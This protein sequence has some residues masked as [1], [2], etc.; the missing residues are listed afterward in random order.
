MFK[1][2]YDPLTGKKT[3]TG[4][5]RGLRVIN[6]YLARSPKLSLKSIIE[7]NK[8]KI[9]AM[10]I[11]KNLFNEKIGEN[12][13]RIRNMFN[14]LLK[15]IDL[16]DKCVECIFHIKNGKYNKNRMKICD[17]GRS[18]DWNPEI[19]SCNNKFFD[20][21]ISK[22]EILHKR[23]IQDFPLSLALSNL[24]VD[25]YVSSLFFQD[26]NL[27]Y[28]DKTNKITKSDKKYMEKNSRS[29]EGFDLTFILPK[30][31]LT[32]SQACLKFYALIIDLR[33]NFSRQILIS[34][35]DKFGENMSSKV[36]T[37]VNEIPY[38]KNK[39]NFNKYDTLAI[40]DLEKVD[41]FN[42]P[43]ILQ[44]LPIN[45]IVDILAK[46][47]RNSKIEYHPDCGG[48]FS[49]FGKSNIKDKDLKYTEDYGCNCICFSMLFLT[50]MES[51][52]YPRELIYSN[53]QYRHWGAS[54]G[55]IA[56]N[57]IYNYSEIK[58]CGSVKR[59]NLIKDRDNV[60]H[61]YTASL[62]EFDELLDIKNISS[63]IYYYKLLE[64]IKKLTGKDMV[65]PH[66]KHLYFRES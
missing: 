2:I 45:K 64:K 63:S 44:I 50:I 3:Y 15:D 43:K 7:T 65:S 6:R 33:N 32:L 60:F 54:C 37:Y 31:Y 10:S 14:F 48:A 55:D 29:W 40:Y 27:F 5:K 39:K 20:S 26:D 58:H 36:F 21:I 28:Y 57:L 24:V 23:F 49:L 17:Y 53:L 47:L 9:K 38:N 35:L 22:I 30:E 11:F 1:Y 52:G 34:L 51:T 42:W 4:G 61:N 25:Y 8:T 66:S 12:R 46:V 19:V 41:I 62:R 13:N 18:V 16:D 56:S 59:F